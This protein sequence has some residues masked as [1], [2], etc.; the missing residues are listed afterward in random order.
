MG[1]LILTA[2]NRH[3]N[4]SMNFAMAVQPHPEPLM[5]LPG[6]VI[7]AR[8]KGYIHAPEQL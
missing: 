4:L 7:R 6:F 8:K 2:E 1:T 5:K 3:Q